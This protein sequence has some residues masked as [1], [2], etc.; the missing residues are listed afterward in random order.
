MKPRNLLLLVASTA[1]LLTAG[2]EWPRHAGAADTA[3]ASNAKWVSS[4]NQ[5]LRLDPDT[6]RVTT[7]SAPTAGDLRTALG[8]A[9]ST[10][11]QGLVEERSPVP[12]GGV[13]VNLQGR[14][15]N[16]ETATIDASGKL[17]AE[18]GNGSPTDGKPAPGR[19]VK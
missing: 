15:Q 5:V 2:D 1:M 3:P 11:D 4:S 12:G 17:H 9:V 8:D 13:M 6:R 10:S 16:A 14:F 18:C 7:L 19:K